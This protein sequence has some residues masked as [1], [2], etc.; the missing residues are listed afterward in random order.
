[1]STTKVCECGCTKLVTLPS[2]NLKICPDCK[3]RITWTKDDEQKPYW[4]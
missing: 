2:Q 1:M 4:G 3:K